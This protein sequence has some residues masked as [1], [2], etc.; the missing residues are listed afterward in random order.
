MEKLNGEFLTEKLVDI[1]ADLKEIMKMDIEWGRT[2]SYEDTEFEFK[3]ICGDYTLEVQ[4]NL[5]L[6]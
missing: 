1:K 5:I 3:G 4:C 2:N 6:N